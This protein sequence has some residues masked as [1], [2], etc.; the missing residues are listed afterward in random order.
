[1]AWACLDLATCA[2]HHRTPT[3]R[4]NTSSRGWARVTTVD[5]LSLLANVTQAQRWNGATGKYWIEHRERHLAEQCNLTPYLFR[6][7]KIS[8]GERVL[9]VGCGCGD[10][11]IKAARI[12]AGG[13]ATRVVAW[14][15]RRKKPSLTPDAVG[16]DL[17]APMLD[18]ARQLATQSGAT[19]VEF[20]QGD[21]QVY[22]FRSNS[23][24]IAISSFGLM[25]F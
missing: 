13:T 9:D 6:A 8:H 18:V 5:A 17:S 23:F 15:L 19:N 10:T 21:A 7:A 4:S 14:L 20:I 12:A 2:H 1:M 25:F 22:P 24:D 11:T 3:G 16:V